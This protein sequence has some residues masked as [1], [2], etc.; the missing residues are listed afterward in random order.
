MK[1]T[2]PTSAGSGDLNGDVN[3]NIGPV[4]QSTKQNS[5][6]EEKIAILVA[7]DN[8]TGG[9]LTDSEDTLCSSITES[10]R[11]RDSERLAAK[12]LDSFHRNAQHFKPPYESNERLHENFERMVREID[13]SP[14]G[15]K[16]ETVII[17]RLLHDRD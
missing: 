11:G 13:S 12:S 3:D 5:S 7:C 6:Y 4:A 2:L 1:L 14:T 10:P 17:R 16:M 15:D 8:T 9:E